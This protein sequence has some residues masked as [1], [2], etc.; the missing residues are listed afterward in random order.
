M[1]IFQWQL[2]CVFSHAA[3]YGFGGGLAVIHRNTFCWIVCA[4]RWINTDSVSVMFNLICVISSQRVT[5][6]GCD[7]VTVHNKL[8]FGQC[9]S[10]FVPSEGEFTGT[11]ALRHRAPC[12]RCAPSKAQT[13][14]VP[15]RCGAQVRQKRVMVVEECK[16]ET[17]SEE[18][19]IDAAAAPMQQL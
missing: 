4:E 9:S 13:V 11:G 6:D 1:L 8:C 3:D 16:C 18:R 14:T 17:G 19:S 10:L 5:A 7:T 2:E 12:S 15:L